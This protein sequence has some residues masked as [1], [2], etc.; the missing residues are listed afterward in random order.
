M[1][2][3]TDWRPPFV[4]NG[5]N[6]AR[7]RFIDRRGKRQVRTGRRSFLYGRIYVDA[8]LTGHGSE[9]EMKVTPDGPWHRLALPPEQAVAALSKHPLSRGRLRRLRAR[10]DFVLK[11]QSNEEE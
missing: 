5:Q 11:D 9:F 7:L 10:P 2:T 3:A 6:G 4:V 8:L 1:A